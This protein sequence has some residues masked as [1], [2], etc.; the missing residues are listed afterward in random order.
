MTDEHDIDE[1]IQRL[2]PARDIDI[3][4]PDSVRGQAIRSQAVGS[5]RRPRRLAVA[6]AAAVVLMGAAAGA[7]VLWSGEPEVLAVAC[8]ADADLDSDRVQGDTTLGVGPEACAP[9]WQQGVF[10]D[11]PAPSQRGANA[12]RRARGGAPPGFRT[13]NQRVKS[14]L[15]YR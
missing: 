7:M 6:I 9:R 8:Y 12:H 10:G 3:P 15:L 11:G 1:L 4:P 2:D 5:P 13:L 14:P